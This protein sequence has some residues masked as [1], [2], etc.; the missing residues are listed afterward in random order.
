[1][2]HPLLDRLGFDV[3]Q[4]R[5]IVQ[6]PTSGTIDPTR[7]VHR[8]MHNVAYDKL[9]RDQLDAIEALNVSDNIKR[10]H[11]NDLME[12]VGDDLRNKRIKLN[13]H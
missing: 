5:N 4:S 1:M 12:N 9:I 13:S 6:L 11:L 2:K 10:I 3:H 7:T 8:G